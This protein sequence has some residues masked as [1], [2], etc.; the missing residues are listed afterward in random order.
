MNRKPDAP[1]QTCVGI[2]R[3]TSSRLAVSLA[4]INRD[5]TRENLPALRLYDVVTEAC[6][7]WLRDNAGKYHK[8]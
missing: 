2:S 4:R 5:R 7:V 6:E 8:S 1:Q 3:E